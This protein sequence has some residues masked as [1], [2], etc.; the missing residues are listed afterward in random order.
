MFY[1]KKYIFVNP[2]YLM[3]FKN[4]RIQNLLLSN[5]KNPPAPLTRGP[6][7]NKFTISEISRINIRVASILKKYVD[8]YNNTFIY[9]Y[10]GFI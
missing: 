5:T 3:N 4:P 6:K 10:M 2:P 8:S 9:K 1:E 7:I